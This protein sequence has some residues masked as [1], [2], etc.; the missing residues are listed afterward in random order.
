[1][2]P[3]EFN[4][5]YGLTWQEKLDYLALCKCCDRHQ[6]NKPNY[7]NSHKERQKSAYK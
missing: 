7:I 6:I 3:E 5:I 4:N 2:N 1:M